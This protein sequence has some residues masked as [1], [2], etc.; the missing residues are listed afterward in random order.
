MFHYFVKTEFQ[1]YLRQRIGT[2]KKIF[3]T[4]SVIIFQITL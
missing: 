2:V 4:D 1:E 3:R